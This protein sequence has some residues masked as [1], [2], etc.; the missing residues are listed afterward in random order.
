MM[1]KAATRT[2]R[3]K[4]LLEQ[5]IA[6]SDGFFTAE[7]LHR[8]VS[9]KDAKLGIATVYRFLR[10]KKKRGG[11]HSYLCDNRAIY[12]K[13]VRSHCHFLCEK[14]GKVTH[15]T[16]DDLDFLKGKVPGDITSIQLEVRGVCRKCTQAARSS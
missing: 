2:T 8:K 5:E 7:G 10:D 1:P 12:S 11:L 14:T 9:G 13:S 4:E 15:F 3:Q 6:H 16:L